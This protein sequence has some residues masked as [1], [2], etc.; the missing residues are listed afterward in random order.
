MHIYVPPKKERKE[1]CDDAHFH[2]LMYNIL[3]WIKNPTEEDN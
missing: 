2:L 1:P 3:G